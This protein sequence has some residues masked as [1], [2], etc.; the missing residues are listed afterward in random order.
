MS[1][2]EI[3]DFIA[4]LTSGAVTEGQ[5]AAFAMAVYF[6]GM[7]LEERVALTRAMTLSGA[8]LDWREAEPA[9]PDARQAFDRRRRR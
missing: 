8:S 6:R 7:T 4:G 9:R 2:G 5:A 1:A 3:G